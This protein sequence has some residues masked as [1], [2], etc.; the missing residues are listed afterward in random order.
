MNI[1]Y[2]FEIA[3][4]DKPAKTMEVVYTSEGR[5]TMRIGARMPFEHES[6]N[7]VVA[8][9][10]P[11]TH[12]MEQDLVVKDVSVGSSGVVTVDVAKPNYQ[13]QIDSLDFVKA[14][15]KLALYISKERFEQS[16]V[17]LGDVRFDSDR[18]EQAALLTTLEVIRSG[19]M[20]S[21]EWRT[22]NGSFVVLDEAKIVSLL[23]AI[24]IHTQTAMSTE[25]TL[26]ALVDAA[27]DKAAVDA[28]AWPA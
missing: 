22:S 27:Q 1:T 14:S 15:K 28:I 19:A 25:K 12:W 20:S 24:A 26:C 16:G 2:S 3:S 23:T 17:S 6:L 9:F 5:Q 4:V 13:E 10:A 7:D 21:V 11:V 8:I 18:C